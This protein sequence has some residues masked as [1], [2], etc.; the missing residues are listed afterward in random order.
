MKLDKVATVLQNVVIE[1][2]EQDKDK[3]LQD[4]STLKLIK[5]IEYRYKVKIG[6]PAEAEIK[7]NKW[8]LYETYGSGNSGYFEKKGL[9]SDELKIML[10]LSELKS[11][12]TEENV[13]EN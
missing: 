4:I 3:I 6:V 12:L 8:M 9:T 10:T 1:I 2:T 13:N 7:N 5:E 11:I